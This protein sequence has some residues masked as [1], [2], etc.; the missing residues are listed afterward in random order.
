MTKTET[1]L[2]KALLK[3]ATFA[4][5]RN[6]EIQGKARLDREDENIL[7]L[8]FTVDDDPQPIDDIFGQPEHLYIRLEIDRIEAHPFG[9]EIHFRNI[10]TAS[11]RTEKH[12]YRCVNVRLDGEPEIYITRY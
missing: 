5:D 12:T 9:P 7:I 11:E 4:I 10:R 6:C 8:D 2:L 1:A 3:A